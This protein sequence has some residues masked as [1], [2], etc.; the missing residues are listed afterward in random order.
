MNYTLLLFASLFLSQT[1][2]AQKE[3][4]LKKITPNDRSEG[5][6][7]GYRS[8]INND[9]C[10]VASSYIDNEV[11]GTIIPD[12]GAAYIFKRQV[13]GDWILHQKLLADTPKHYDFFGS[14]VCMN[15]QFIFVSATGDD[16]TKDLTISSRKGAVY[17]YKKSKDG[18]FALAQKIILSN[19]NNIDSFGETMFVKDSLLAIGA[20]GRTVNNTKLSG[21]VFIYKLSKNGNWELSATVLPPMNNGEMFGS[22]ICLTKNKLVIASAIPERAYVFE[23][24]NDSTYAFIKELLPNISNVSRVGSS[25]AMND[26]F[27]FLGS[28]GKFYNNGGKPPCDS[29]GSL[30]RQKKLLGAGIVYVYSNKSGKYELLQS[31]TPLKPTADMYFGHD[32]SL[33]GN[34]LIIS[35][36]GERIP[37][38]KCEESAFGGAAYLFELQGH[39]WI[40]KEKIVS[41]IRSHWDKFAYSVAICSDYLIIGS[42]FDAEDSNEQN[43]KAEAGSAYIM[44]LR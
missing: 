10:I 37:E 27:I 19:R 4:T 32:M 41:P 13:N 1:V 21:T 38:V 42:R 8:D 12:A 14:A 23:R 9:Y 2:L 31:L 7:F 16:N 15:D 5:S 35:A 40:Q 24:R 33:S 11:N 6:Q 25:I 30:D 22:E 36:I 43:Y 3:S 26:E 44:R 18:K 29:T 28:T 17:V 39:K 34:N 20:F